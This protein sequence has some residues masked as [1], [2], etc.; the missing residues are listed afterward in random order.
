[1]KKV[2]DPL[3][4][5]VLMFD[6]S[7]ELSSI[8]I[9]SVSVTA[10]GGAGDPTPLNLLSGAHQIS[11]NKVYQRISGGVD[12]VR[13]KTKCVGTKG[14]DIIVRKDTIYIED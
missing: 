8:D 4:S 13:Y 1:M 2:K 14:S 5:V 9:A 12:G 6:F 10:Y 3:E 11:G 7:G